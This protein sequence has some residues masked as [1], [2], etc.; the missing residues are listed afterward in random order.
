MGS[1]IASPI[2]LEARS[3]NDLAKSDYLY[4]AMTALPTF[5]LILGGNHVKLDRTTDVFRIFERLEISDYQFC[6][7]RLG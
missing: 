4:A 1:Q 7:Y 6:F 3:T 5:S 2:R